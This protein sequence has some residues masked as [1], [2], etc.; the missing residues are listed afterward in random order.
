[1][2]EREE[3][4]SREEVPKA[5]RKEIDLG[6]KMGFSI[7]AD[8]KA[9]LR[10]YWRR[11]VPLSALVV[12]PLIFAFD[13]S[14]R[15][16]L[17]NGWVAVNLFTTFVLRPALTYL[18]GRSLFRWLRMDWRGFGFLSRHILPSMPRPL[19]FL[20][21]MQRSPRCLRGSSFSSSRY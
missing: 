17:M 11:D 10:R 8:A 3:A 14:L 19:R 1:M 2:T 15:F 7:D 18:A 12:F 5:P 4:I 21:N 6:A 20:R 13:Q 16:G 9:E